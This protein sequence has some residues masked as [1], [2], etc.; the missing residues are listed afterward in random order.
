MKVTLIYKPEE[1]ELLL[2]KHCIW[3][4]MGRKEAPKKPPSSKLLRDVLH[5]RHSPVRVLNF[6]FLIEDIPSNIA[7]HLARHVHAVPFVSSL[8]NDRQERMDGDN[9]PR[10]TP[11]DMIFYCNA[12]E[13]MTFANKRLCG[14]AAK[15]TQQVARMMCDEA[16]KAMPELSGDLVPM[17]IYHGGVCHELES[18]G[19][20][21]CG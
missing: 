15:R 20:C 2:F 1:R 4:T 19:R 8:R 18:C 9:A 16:E 11:V 7:T 5:A 3:V 21:V 14:R 13:L 12:E 6:A 17:C 10:N